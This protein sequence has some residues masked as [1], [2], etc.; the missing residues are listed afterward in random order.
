MEKE[1]YTVSADSEIN[2]SYEL[3]SLVAIHSKLRRKQSAS[4]LLGVQ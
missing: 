4:R 1:T 3:T 2:N